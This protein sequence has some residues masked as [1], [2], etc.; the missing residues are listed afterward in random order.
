MILN[1]HHQDS[2]FCRDVFLK[3]LSFL[4]VKRIIPCKSVGKMWYSKTDLSTV[5][6]H[7]KV[8]FL[9]KPNHHGFLKI[10]KNRG[11]E[12]WVWRECHFRN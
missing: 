9:Q 4:G 6:C 2:C 12:V 3:A 8:T 10:S 1:M 11:N 5:L 7:V